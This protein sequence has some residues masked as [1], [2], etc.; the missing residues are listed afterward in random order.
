MSLERDKKEND[1][2]KKCKITRNNEKIFFE[3]LWP[4]SIST[5]ISGTPKSFIHLEFTSLNL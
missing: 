4:I 3:M 2:M 5:E 1:A